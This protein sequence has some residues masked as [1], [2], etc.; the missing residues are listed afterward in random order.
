MAECATDRLILALDVA[1][2]A[3]AE[4]LVAATEGVVGVYKIGLEFA[5][6]GGI[7]TAAALA[8]A[9]HR[10]FLDMK[11]LDIGNT[12]AGA[13]RAAGALGAA[14]LTVHAYPQALAAAVGAR[15]AGL[16]IVA[17]TVLT[18]MG[19]DDVA[20]AG[21][22]DR[23]TALVDRRIAAAVTAGA[24]AIVCAPGE[25]AA[26]RRSGLTVITPGVRL[27]ADAAGDQRRVATP[28]EAIATGADAIVVGRPIGASADPR[29]AAE[30]YLA[31]IEEGLALRR[32]A[33][34]PDGAPRS[35]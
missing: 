2:T 30:R 31:A 12:V 18:S 35:I 34:S 8:R 33:A 7:G 20:A 24:D 21:Y 5:L 6:A 17:V 32:A 26:A 1:D 29:A 15:P 3:A 16:S 27:P 23:V 13:T 10:V 22:A 11:L 28:Q 25:A 19:E 4:R 14:Y 9:G